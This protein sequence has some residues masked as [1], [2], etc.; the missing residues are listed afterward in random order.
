MKKTFFITTFA[1][2][3]VAS[4]LLLTQSVSAVETTAGFKCTAGWKKVIT[5]NVT[6]GPSNSAGT[7]TI[8]GVTS[9]QVA[10]L[11]TAVDNGCDVKV[12]LVGQA[13]SGSHSFA[14]DN[15]SYDNAMVS[16]EVN[17]PLLR[18]FGSSAL[19]SNAN[20]ISDSV[21]LTGTDSVTFGL[22]RLYTSIYDG[23]TE[24]AGENILG[25]E[26][27]TVTRKWTVKYFIKK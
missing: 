16:C 22:D 17:R 9:A 25:Y 8:T 24:F 3:I 19:R 4:T 14:C 20:F 2:A 1:F 15:I 5:G 11:A 10:Q 12:V 27:P 21:V 23:K 7:P 6:Y 26:R 18:L 13:N